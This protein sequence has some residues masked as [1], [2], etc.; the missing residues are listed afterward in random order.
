M[1]CSLHFLWL[2]SPR[3]QCVEQG[4][5]IC[6][7]FDRR[8]ICGSRVRSFNRTSSEHE[9]GRWWLG[10]RTSLI[11]SALTGNSTLHIRQ[12]SHHRRTIISRS[13]CLPNRSIPQSCTLPLAWSLA[14]A[15]S[16]SSLV[17]FGR[18]KGGIGQNHKQQ[19]DYE[20][21]DKIRLLLFVFVHQSVSS[22]IME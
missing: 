9:G 12:P 13:S 22:P 5:W 2:D 20:M 3:R 16:A 11:S 6:C 7:W 10:R 1:S 8:C 17:L 18:V 14:Y 21:I 19:P 15:V 4:P